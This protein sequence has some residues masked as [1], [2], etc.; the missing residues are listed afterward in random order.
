MEALIAERSGAFLHDFQDAAGF[1]DRTP[2]VVIGE[3]FKYELML[4]TTAPDAQSKGDPQIIELGQSL[5]LVVNE[6][7]AL[8][9]RSL[10]P[11]GF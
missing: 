4:R 10:D 3:D 8:G 11:R 9:N 5:Q 6:L 1:N 2:A 7:D